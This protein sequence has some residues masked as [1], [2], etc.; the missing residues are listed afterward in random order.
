MHNAA[1]GLN[2]QDIEADEE[3]LS[4]NEEIVLLVNGTNGTNGTHVV[5]GV[6]G[7]NGVKGGVANKTSRLP[8]MSPI[9]SAS[10]V[11]EAFRQ[12]KDATNEFIVN[13]QLGTYYYNVIPRSTAVCIGHILD[14]FEELGCSIRSATPVQKLDRVSYLPKHEKFMDLIYGLLCKDARFIDIDGSE[15]RRTA[16]AP[17]TKSVETLLQELLRDEL[18]HTAE[19]KLTSLIGARFADCLT[20]KVEGLQIIFGTSEGRELVSDVYAKSP[21]NLNWIQQAK[22][23]IEQL[24][25]TQPKNGEP[26]HIP[27][28]GAGTGGTTATLVPMLAQLGV[29]IKYTMTDLSSSLIAAARRRFEKYPFM[30]IKVL[31]MESPPDEGLLHSQHMVIANS[32]VDATRNLATLTANIHKILRPDG[33]LLLL[34]MTEQVPWVDFIFGTLGGWWLFEDGRQHALAPVPH[35]N[36]ILRSVGYGHVN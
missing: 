1:L 31:N 18:A 3:V 36:K 11:L 32:C 16:V 6:D 30:E 4:G 5:N 25:L 8:A 12:A 7:V 22:W 28:V 23:F 27:E 33:F 15:I 17:P 35:W 29:P 9:L 14:A 19:H 34:E 21:I 10:T 2:S 20:G 24:L 13:G 26:W